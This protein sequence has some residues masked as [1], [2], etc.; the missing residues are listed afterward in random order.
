L[1]GKWKVAE[2]EFNGAKGPE[3][4][5]KKGRF[6]FA[7]GTFEA[8]DDSD[9]PKRKGRFVIDSGRSP[10][11][12]DFLWQGGGEK[13]KKAIGI[14]AFEAGKL[15]ICLTLDT[16]VQPKRPEAFKTQVGDGFVVYTLE[17]ARP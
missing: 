14:F 15:K 10:K 2:A 12:I 13:E 4:E 11:T 7:E 16:A 6:T 1:Q 5:V 9:A 8:G 3:A 17:R